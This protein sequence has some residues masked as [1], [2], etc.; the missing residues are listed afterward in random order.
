MVGDLPEVRSGLSAP[1][2]GA[3]G[4]V[5]A[6]GTTLRLANFL[7]QVTFNNLPGD[8]VR[9]AKILLIDLLGA[10]LGAQGAPETGLAVTVFE[11][12]GG[13][14]ESSI[15][16]RGSQTNC[17]NAA[18]LNS[19]ASHVLELDDTHL[20]TLTH[21]GAVVIP[22]ALAMSERQ[23]LSG[24]GTL[25][26]I[27]V[28]YE[29]CL[30][31]AAAIQPSHW[32]QGF[33]SMGTC[34]VF[35]AAAAAGHCLGFDGDRLAS[36][37][38][39]AGMQASSTNASSYGQGDM[40]RRLSPSH[41]AGAGVVS[42]LLA[43][44]GFTGTRGILEGR[45]GFLQCFAQEHDIA[46]IT[47]RLGERYMITEVGLK[48]YSCNRLH[49]SAI[50]GLLGLVHQHSLSS[51]MIADVL[52]TTFDAAVSGR[53]NRS[54]PTTLFDAKMSL[55][56]SLAVAC[57]RGG[58]GEREFSQDCIA[59]AR[60]QG[61]AAKV[62]VV[63]DPELTSLFPR[64][65]PAKVTLTTTRGQSHEM[66]VVDPKGEPDAP[67]TPAEVKLKFLDLAASAVSDSVAAAI[68]EEVHSLDRRADVERLMNLLRG[69]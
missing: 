27:V 62:R 1:Q 4:A 29:A 11:E 43:E 50:D 23:R 56:F 63:S 32:R 10:I 18:L 67:M 58:A 2:A 37:F 55:P 8:T 33:L 21:A 6:E 61:F 51:D 48:P 47:D 16:G 24:A 9:A 65:W 40:G 68:L 13:R 7:A 22:T 12:L 31:V 25:A 30:R 14:E 52:V 35:G 20:P 38:G 5:P 45:N 42:S 44:K 39:L 66:L 28:G 46:R 49:H 60:L 64:K 36:A 57:I 26:A 59:D 34:G 69:D 15:I 53:P 54:R 41:A 17:Q 19:L 3:Q